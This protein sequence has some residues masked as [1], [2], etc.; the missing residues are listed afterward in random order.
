MALR[1]EALAAAASADS[2]LSANRPKLDLVADAT[3]QQSHFKRHDTSSELSVKL[4]FSLA[5]YDGGASQ[6]RSR[7]AKLEA[8]ARS[9]DAKTADLEISRQV[10]SSWFA[11]R[12]SRLKTASLRN[13][14]VLEQKAM[15]I[16]L[17]RFAAGLLSLEK[18]LNDQASLSATEFSLLTVETEVRYNLFRVLAGTG[19]LASALG[20]EL[21]VHDQNYD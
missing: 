8:N 17:K 3:H 19:Q 16:N 15:S 14:L 1:Y 10:R 4:K 7:Q 11:V 13:K 6:A 20:V 12:E 18:I 5:L 21:N 9:L 2:A